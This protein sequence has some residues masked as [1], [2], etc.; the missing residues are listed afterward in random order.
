[1]EVN[2]EKWICASRRELCGD[3]L[4]RRGQRRRPGG[5]IESRTHSPHVGGSRASGPY[6]RVEQEA[7]TVALEFGVG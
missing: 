7:A 2:D 6:S 5:A 4:G 1:M 3:P